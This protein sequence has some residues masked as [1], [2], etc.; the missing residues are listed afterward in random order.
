MLRRKLPRKITNHNYILKWVIRN[1]HYSIKFA[2]DQHARYC[3]QTHTQNAQF[4]CQL[5]VKWRSA[6]TI[7]SKKQEIS[8]SYLIA[9]KWIHAIPINNNIYYLE[10]Y[11]IN[12][13]S[14]D[15]NF[16]KMLFSILFLSS[17]WNEN[18]MIHIQAH[19][20]T[21]TDEHDDIW[22]QRNILFTHR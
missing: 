16:N 5:D 21:N 18:N 13:Y 14:F 1:G 10:N 15:A 3:P 20:H 17:K 4:A 7:Q 9:G 2:S 8:F 22:M 12:L 6:N 11:R 19:V